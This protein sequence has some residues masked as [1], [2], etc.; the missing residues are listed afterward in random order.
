MKKRYSKIIL[1]L[2]CLTLALSFAACGNDKDKEEP[3]SEPIEEPVEE[4]L[5]VSDY[6]V[7]LYFA[8]LEYIETGDETFPALVGPFDYILNDIEDGSQYYALLEAM[9]SA[10]DYQDAYTTLVPQRVVNSV[11]VEGGVAYV[12]FASPLDGSALDESLM[13]NQIVTALTE[14]FSEIEKVQ[15][16]LDGE[17]V[18]T[19]M[20]HIAVDE[21]FTRAEA[22]NLELQADEGDGDA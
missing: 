14:S 1:A 11:Q 12:D 10:E 2:L 16:T 18:D 6:D 7:Q 22:E 17:V 20:G 21:P 15:F 13:I 9:K 19:L 5:A 8:N 3:A 4:S